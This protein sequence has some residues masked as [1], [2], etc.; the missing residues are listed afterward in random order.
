MKDK[1]LIFEKYT[2]NVR[3]IES[4]VYADSTYRDPNKELT[5]PKNPELGGAGYAIG[6]YASKAGKDPYEIALTISGLVKSKLFVP[7]NY[8]FKGKPYDLEYPGT[9]EELE[10][11]IAALI[12]A[13]FARYGHKPHFRQAAHAARE[14][15][16]KVLNVSKESGGSRKF[17]ATPPTHNPRI[18][19]S[20]KDVDDVF[21][22]IF[23]AKITHAPTLD[24]NG[25]Y[26]ITTLVAPELEKDFGVERGR[27]A[28]RVH[29]IL[30]PGQRVT[31]AEFLNLISRELSYPYT[32]A[33]RACNDLLKVGGMAHV[34]V[35]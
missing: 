16:G 13:E 32:I 31:G 30:E 35:P 27:Q 26:E 3:V 23:K 18:A 24:L 14:I 22:R 15:A 28:E 34:K 7:G 12:K 5:V 19:V 21:E 9:R 25:T 6:T 29:D 20:S 10:T 1:E 2:R 8:N 17:G 4:P 11:E 33:K